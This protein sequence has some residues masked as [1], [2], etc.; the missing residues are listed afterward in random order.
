MRRVV[1][2]LV[3][4]VAIG[5]Q[6][7]LLVSVSD[8]SLYVAENFS[9]T[10]DGTGVNYSSRN[11]FVATVDNTGKIVALHEGETEIDV[12][13]REGET[14]VK[15]TVKSH[16]NDIVIPLLEW[17]ISP[18]Q[19]KNR[20]GKPYETTDEACLYVYGDAKNDDVHIGTSYYFENERLSAV[21]LVFNPTY[22]SRALL[23]LAERWQYYGEI[24][25]QY[26][27]GDT[28]EIEDAETLILM[29]KQS[30]TWVAIFTENN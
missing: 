14:S 17:G 28:L 15:V 23:N 25:N 21:M 30:G 3:A 20:V 11:P 19:L 5:C 7:S 4:L 2:F 9:L 16:Y 13:A 12:V 29:T 1:L 18:N 10:A 24:A 8:I 22:T 6:S 26:V 27:L